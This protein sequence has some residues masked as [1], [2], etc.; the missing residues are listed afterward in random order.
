MCETGRCIM[1][2]TGICINHIP[3][4]NNYLR[5]LQGAA[6][7]MSCE[8]CLIGKYNWAALR[9]NSFFARDSAYVPIVH[10]FLQGRT[11]K[12]IAHVIINFTFVITDYCLV[13]LVGFERFGTAIEKHRKI[14]AGLL[15]I[16][17]IYRC[18]PKLP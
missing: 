6:K 9:S 13:V 18:N 5:Y 3:V 15:N 14:C 17:F 10:T 1:S 2:I 4:T 12:K 16:V 11:R 8:M 7:E